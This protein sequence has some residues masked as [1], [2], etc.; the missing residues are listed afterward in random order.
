MKKGLGTSGWKKE[1]RR[2]KSV[3]GWPFSFGGRN[4]GKRVGHSGVVESGL[5]CCKRRELGLGKEGGFSY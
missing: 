1:N 4:K 5:S 3:W 2:E